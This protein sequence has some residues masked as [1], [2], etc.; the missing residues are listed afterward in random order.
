MAAK[1]GITRSDYY[2]QALAGG[3]PACGELYGIR[4]DARRKG[5]HRPPKLRQFGCK[6]PVNFAGQANIAG[7]KIFCSALRPLA[8]FQASHLPDEG[9]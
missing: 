1:R 2:R 5:F 4:N 6:R 8:M 9:G 7:R 3:C